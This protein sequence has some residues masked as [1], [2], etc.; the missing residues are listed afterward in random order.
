MYDVQL[1]SEM[2]TSL[3]TLSNNHVY[4]RGSFAL[5]DVSCSDYLYDKSSFKII[6]TFSSPC[7]DNLLHCF[8]N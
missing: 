3:F 6:I 2:S 1:K 5:V 8:V 4:R 7:N